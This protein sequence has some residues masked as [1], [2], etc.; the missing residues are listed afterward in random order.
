VSAFRDATTIVESI[1][2][3]WEVRTRAGTLESAVERQIEAKMEVI[4]KEKMMRMMIMM[5]MM[6]VMRMT[7]M[8]GNPDVSVLRDKSIVHR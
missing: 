1:V 7:M 5:M 2:T 8:T 3:R 6:K 4:T